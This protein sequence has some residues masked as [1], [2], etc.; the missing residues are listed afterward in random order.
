VRK[1]QININ[2]DDMMA[3]FSCSENKV[4]RVQQTVKVQQLTL[5]DAWKK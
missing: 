3:G 2:V 4:Q 1:Y 5:T